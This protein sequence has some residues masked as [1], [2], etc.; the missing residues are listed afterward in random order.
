MG[1]NSVSFRANAIGGKRFPGSQLR[2]MEGIKV[3]GWV[4]YEL[5]EKLN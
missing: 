4:G 5:V 3:E 2:M 1:F